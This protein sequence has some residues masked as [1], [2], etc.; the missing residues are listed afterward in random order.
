MELFN[1]WN[2]RIND[3][4]WGYLLSTALLVGSVWFRHRTRRA[5]FRLLSVSI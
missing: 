2:T 1:D 3:L 4:L 5:L